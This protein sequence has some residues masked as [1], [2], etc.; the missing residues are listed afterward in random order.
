MSSSARPK[1]ILLIIADQYRHPGNVTEQTEGF[2]NHLKSILG[3]Q[4]DVTSANPYQEFFPGLMRLRKNAVVLKNHM[5]AS[6]ACIPSRSALFTGQYGTRT[7]VTQTDGIFKSGEA[8]QFP[9]LKQDGIPTLGNWMQAAGYRTHYFGKWHLSHPSISSLK[10]FGFDN[11]ELS[12]PEPHGSLVNNLG[13]YRDPIFADSACSFLRREGLGAPFGISLA[14][15]EQ[16]DPLGNV[17]NP[18][19]T[20]PWFAVV[21]FVNPHDI[22][23]YPAVTA[24]AL[25][26]ANSESSNNNNVT[27]SPLGP[28][29][30]PKHGEKSVFPVGGTMKVPLNEKG[31]PQANSEI[32]PTYNE[33]LEDKPSCQKDY[34]YKMGLSLSSKMGLNEAKNMEK[35]GAITQDNVTN[36]AVNVALR[37]SIPFALAENK[38]QVSLKF[39]QFYAYLHAL[40]DTHINRVLQTL[41]ETGQAENTIVVFLTDHGECGAAHHMMME[42]WHTAYEE[43]L[44]V[45]AVIKLPSS[46]HANTNSKDALREIQSLTSHVDILPTIL[47]L[48]GIN[49]EK[50]QEIAN[51]FL[52]NRPIPPFPGIDLSPL[53]LNN[54]HD[55][56][57]REKDGSRRQGVLFITDDEITA[58]LQTSWQPYENLKLEEFEVFNA[59]VDAIRKGMVPGK[60]V[61]DLSPGSVRQP[62]HIRCVRTEEY[63]LV[64]Y[65]DPSGI[66]NEEW[67]MYHLGNDPYEAINL[68]EVK[69]SPPI[70]RS[71]L[72]SWINAGT[73][74]EMANSLVNLLIS[75]ENKNL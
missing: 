52:K 4:G 30:V 16:N 5:I 25:P 31:F 9:W 50:R 19:E 8:S 41:E 70:P 65:F 7:G 36:Y 67:E 53:I 49:E 62:N 13:I 26:N 59:T 54:Q 75:L 28:L 14:K 15:Q 47:G 35:N 72:P 10:E 42:K 60:V 69:V 71:N 6:S 66:E 63:K 3:F 32:V 11:W 45:P 37:S 39:I 55:G 57:V 64:R 21:S 51:K 2:D 40:M 48:A 29:S 1:N 58:P 12:Y 23:T 73:V 74:Q 43:V 68:L 34:A 38:E 22:A 18:A 46:I 56:I 17:P 24:V 61:T 44:H 27:Q 33:T 20:P